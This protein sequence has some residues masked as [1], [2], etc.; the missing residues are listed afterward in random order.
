MPIPASYIV[1]VNVGTMAAGANNLDFHGLVLT[2]NATLPIGAVYSFA[3]VKGVQEYFGYESDEAKL[4]AIYFAGYVGAS[5][6][7]TKLNLSRFADSYYAA[8]LRGARVTKSVDDL[9]TGIGALFLT[10]SGTEKTFNVSLTSAT[11]YS[12]IAMLLQSAIRTA[13][14]GEDDDDDISA[15]TAATVEYSSAFGAFTIM[16]GDTG[17]TSTIAY[18]TGELAVALNLTKDLGAVLSAGTDPVG[19]AKTMTGITDV[20]S[21]WVNFMTAWTP[22][23]DD[24]LGFTQWANDQGVDYLFL[25][26]DTDPNL[27]LSNSTAT[28]AQAIKDANLAGV[29]GC[30]GGQEYAAF[31][32]AIAAS[33]DWNRRNGLVTTAFKSQ[34]GVAANVQTGTNAQNLEAQNMNF[35]GN[36]ATRND[37]FVFNYPGVMFGDAYGYIDTYWSAVWIK[38]QI[39]AACMSGLTSVGRV[40]YTEQGC[41]IVRA[42]IMDVVNRG[43][44]NGVISAGVVLSEAQKAQLLTEVGKD[45]S[46]QLFADGYYLAIKDPGANARV[47]RESPIVYFYFTYAGAVHRLVVPV[48]M[49]L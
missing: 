39:Q 7:P 22:D 24:I 34:G 29:A 18:A 41:T 5:K 14:E 10:L 19:Y 20:D 37:Q 38:N 23:E 49:I 45:V 16:N 26:G 8:W 4:A 1:Q 43:L 2:K 30:Y 15:F 47:R 44:L 12:D 25:Y 42:W 40:P 27:L 33:I 17:D 35:M 13:G 48:R 9:K 31:I 46:T 28:I 6:M 11:T 21:N 3:D 36:F 32:M